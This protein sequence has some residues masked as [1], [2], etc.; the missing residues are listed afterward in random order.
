MTAPVP[1]IPGAPQLI[2][3]GLRASFSEYEV[4]KGSPFSGYDQLAT[5]VMAGASFDA[6]A[7]VAPLLA[8]I[9][10]LGSRISGLENQVSALAALVG[11]LNTAIPVQPTQP[12]ASVPL[13]QQIPTIS[14]PLVPSI[15]QFIPLPDLPSNTPPT[16]S[17]GHL[18][19]PLT[20][21]F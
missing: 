14:T 17:G 11:G 4:A 5:A 3:A 12:T 16:S 10:S 7:R 8:L 1:P 2:S 9:G 13:V 19:P 18:R 6:A 21:I 20:P 15:P